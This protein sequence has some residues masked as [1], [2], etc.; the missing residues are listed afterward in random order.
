M[1]RRSSASGKSARSRRPKSAKSKGRNPPKTTRPSRSGAEAEVTELRR[2]LQEALEQQT[3]TSDVLKII[4]SSTFDLQTVLQTLVESAAKLCD[5]DHAVITREK[6]G[7]FYRAE[8]YGWPSEF[9]DYVRGI[10]VEPERGSA[11][12]RV[13]LERKMVHIPDVQADPEYTLTDFRK[14]LDFRTV[15]AVPMLREGFPIGVLILTRSEVRPFTAKQIDLVTTFADQAV[16]AIEN[17]RLL[18][19]LRQ[20]T[21]DLSEALERQTATSEVLQVIS[22]S[23][24]ELQ[25]VFSTMLEKAVRICDARVG[26]IYRLDDDVLTLIAS[27]T[28]LPLLI[29][30]LVH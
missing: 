10:P 9:M 17:A 20:R 14:F 8:A 11:I 12:G 15:L 4:S 19:E 7:V 2:E 27:Q 1:K 16:I 28:R 23:P 21:I 5:A 30:A 26:N 18:S 3:A 29:I 24:G 25:P 6:K 22:S 13:L